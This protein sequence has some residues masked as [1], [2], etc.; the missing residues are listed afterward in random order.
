MDAELRKKL[1]AQLKRRAERLA[2]VADMQHCPDVVLSLTVE[3]VVTTAMMLCGDEVAKAL[4]RKIL[5]DRRDVVGICMCGERELA[6]GKNLC[7]Q[8]WDAVDDEDRD[9]ELQ[10]LLDSETRG[11]PS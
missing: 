9:V 1:Q 3:H 5:Q 2:K 4:L 6:H 8:C 10:R 11:K 7:Q